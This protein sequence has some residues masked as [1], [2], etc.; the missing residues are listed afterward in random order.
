MG[1]TAALDTKHTSLH[2]NWRPRHASALHSGCTRGCGRHSSLH[3][4]GS[5]NKWDWHSSILPLELQRQH[6]GLATIGT[7]MRAYPFPWEAIADREAWLRARANRSCRGYPW[8]RLVEQ[9]A[10]GYK[11]GG[12]EVALESVHVTAWSNPRFKRSVQQLPTMR[13]VLDNAERAAGTAPN[14]AV[15]E[16]MPECLRVA[17][18]WLSHIEERDEATRRRNMPITL[19]SAL[20]EEAESSLSF[21]RFDGSLKTVRRVQQQCNVR[22]PNP[23]RR[24]GLQCL[25]PIGS[26]C[27]GTYSCDAAPHKDC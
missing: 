20:A 10:R 6:P 24:D 12:R 19:A 21:T 7:S 14:G 11:V 22:N 18:S 4:V 26:P 3:R 1:R 15:P 16:A 5:P 13:A 9:L 27:L 2:F 17:R 23:K 25:W 8:A